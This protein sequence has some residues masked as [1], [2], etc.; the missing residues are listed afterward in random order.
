LA[1]AG[2]QLL[3]HEEDYT[4]LGTIDPE[5]PD[6]LWISTVVDPRDGTALPVHEIFHG[7]TS[8]AGRSWAWTPV[9]EGSAVSNFRPIAVP[10]DPSREVLAWYRGEMRSS[11]AYDTEVL[12]RQ[13]RR[14]W[15]ATA[16]AP[17]PS[18]PT[19]HSRPRTHG[20][21]L[22]PHAMVSG[23]SSHSGDSSATRAGAARAA[24]GR[25]TTSASARSIT[26]PRAAAASCAAT[27]TC[28]LSTPTSPHTTGSIRPTANTRRSGA[29]RGSTRPFSPIPPSTSSSS[30]EAGPSRRSVR[31]TWRS[32]LVNASSSYCARSPVTRVA[33]ASAGTIPTTV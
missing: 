12:V 31:R 8:D 21:M 22:K 5:D 23:A 32:V 29:R 24:A 20:G 15:S 14:G 16:S 30:A 17:P 13:L 18:Q 4:G 26:S 33:P 9:T 19:P 25:R 3:A 11:Q 28:A 2:P 10:G 6:A 1:H 27:A 7:R